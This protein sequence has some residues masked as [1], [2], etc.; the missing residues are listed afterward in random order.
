VLMRARR[1][2]LLI[3]PAA[4]GTRTRTHP[5]RVGVSVVPA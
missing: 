3:G 1:S 2:V 5:A 4:F